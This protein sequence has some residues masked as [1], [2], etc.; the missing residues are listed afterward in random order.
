MGKNAIFDLERSIC[1]VT[2][3]M[4]VESIT[5]AGVFWKNLHIVLKKSQEFYTAALGRF[6]LWF[7]HLRCNLSGDFGTPG[8]DKRLL[9]FLNAHCAVPCFVCTCMIA[10]VRGLC[11]RVKVC[12]TESG[13]L[14][15]PFSL[16]NEPRASE[17]IA[18]LLLQCFHRHTQ[19]AS[20]RSVKFPLWN[21]SHIE[22]P[23]PVAPEWTAV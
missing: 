18:L 15:G 10:L 12:S 20:L 2:F 19:S 3:S 23:L 14:C 17:H 4:C 16:I 21:E 1:S 7:F 6:R 9:H 13:E 22:P 11:V 5:Y 8:H